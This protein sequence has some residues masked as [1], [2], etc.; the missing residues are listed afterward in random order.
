M[1]KLFEERFTSIW[2]NVIILAKEG[3][4]DTEQSFQVQEN[5]ASETINRSL[6]NPLTCDRGRWEEEMI[7]MSLGVKVCL[8]GALTAVAELERGQQDLVNS[9]QCL[10]YTLGPRYTLYQLPRT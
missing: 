2:E 1:I 10:A 8:Q 7:E 9:I 5:A 4:E 6:T 3:K